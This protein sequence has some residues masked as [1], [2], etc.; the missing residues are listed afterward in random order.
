VKKQWHSKHYRFGFQCAYCKK[1]AYSDA[2]SKWVSREGVAFC[3]ERH[4][5]QYER[6]GAMV[7]A[8]VA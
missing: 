6:G 3:C 7:P 1:W 2:P 4:A 5:R 8:E